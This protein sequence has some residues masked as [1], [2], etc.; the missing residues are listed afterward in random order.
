MTIQQAIKSKKPFANPELKF[1]II[2]KRNR[3]CIESYKDKTKI[4]VLQMEVSTTKSGN[5][6]IKNAK[7]KNRLVYICPNTL[8]KNNWEIKE[9]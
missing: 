4:L 8:L 6:K 5:T 2:V 9:N 3:F 7:W 1:W